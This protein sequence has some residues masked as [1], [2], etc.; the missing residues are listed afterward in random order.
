MCLFRLLYC[1]YVRNQVRHVNFLSLAIGG[2]LGSVCR[3]FISTKVEPFGIGTFIVNVT[4]SVLLSLIVK[5][6]ILNVISELVLY[7]VGIGFCGAFTTFS[8]FGYETLQ[9][10]L[11]K[12]YL[13]AFLYSLGTAIISFITV[14]FILVL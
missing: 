4:G 8:T 7:A 5:F 6:Y 13:L 12:K 2:C 9:L 3:Y 11:N 10:I 1:P 14:Y